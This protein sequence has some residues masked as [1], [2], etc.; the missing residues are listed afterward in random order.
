MDKDMMRRV[1]EAVGG[2]HGGGAFRERSNA[3]G[4]HCSNLEKDLCYARQQSQHAYVSAV[5]PVELRKVWEIVG[6]F[7]TVDK[8]PKH[9]PDVQP[10]AIRRPVIGTITLEESLIKLDN[11]RFRI[12]FSVADGDPL[13]CEGFKGTVRL[14]A[15]TESETETPM[16]FVEWEAFWEVGVE[17]QRDAML[18]L[19]NTMFK[20]EKESISALLK[21][22]ADACQDCHKF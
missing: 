18:G 22:S 5:F 17:A 21:A 16:T 1:L 7:A 14:A 2:G 8:W 9:D 3:E 13:Q 4:A 10:G 15:V 12:H 6:N 20:I 11:D 19:V